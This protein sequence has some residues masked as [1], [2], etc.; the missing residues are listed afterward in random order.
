MSEVVHGGD[1]LLYINTGDESTPVWTPVAHATTH[2]VTHGMSAQEVS[3]KDTGRHPN[4]KPGKHNVS[5]VSIQGLRTYDGYDYFDLK[6]IFDA[7][8]L[9]HIKLSGRPSDD[10]DYFERT[11]Q[12]GDKYEEGYG[13]ITE[14]SNE[15]A[16]DG[17]ATYSC[18]I[19]INGK[20]EI[21]TVSG[22]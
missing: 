8:Q 16:H 4:L 11:E 5:T 12:A 7:N 3:S 17:I 19:S 2:S 10:P 14:L 18:T 20:T 13:Y 9:V 1:V 15:N 21:K 6:Q 22:S